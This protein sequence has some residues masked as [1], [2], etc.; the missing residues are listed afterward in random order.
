MIVTACEKCP[1]FTFAS[2][3]EYCGHPSDETFRRQPECVEGHFVGAEFVPATY[4]IPS[5][6]PLRVAPLTLEVAK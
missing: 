3:G 4:P 5:W 6:C 1:C 2:D